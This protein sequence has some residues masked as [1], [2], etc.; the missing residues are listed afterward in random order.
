MSGPCRVTAGADIDMVVTGTA[1]V[2]SSGVAAVALN[3]TAVSPSVATWIAA[4]PAGA[5][6]PVTSSLYVP[7]RSIRAGLIVVPIG[8]G[9]RIRL[10]TGSGNTDLL[11]DVVGYHPASGGARYHPVAP[12]RLF[13]TRNESSAV[14]G[15]T[16]RVVG[17]SGRAGVPTS[18]VRAVAVNVTTMGAS[19]GGHVAMTPGTSTGKPTTPSVF[20]TSGAPVSNRA[21]VP[22]SADGSIR[23]YASVTTHVVIDVV[24]WFGT[25]GAGA[26]SYHPVRPSRVL[27]SRKGVGAIG[28]VMAGSPPSV[29]VAG[30]GGVPVGADAVVMT[31]TAMQ[32]TRTTYVRAWRAGTRQPTAFDVNVPAAGIAGNLV[33]VRSRPTGASSWPTPPGPSTSWATCAATTPELS[34]RR[35]RPHS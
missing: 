35:E 25:A 13:D 24:G 14:I 23:A 18:G 1:G 20:F 31:L 5:T 17:V 15:G 8:S 4:S 26:L 28:P 30:R 19:S 12:T 27:D 11:V 9:G 29:L 10:R 22:V 3:V 21:L 16:G 6:F 7:A 2:P 32:P 33:L 34:S